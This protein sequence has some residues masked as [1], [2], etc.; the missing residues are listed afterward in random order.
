MVSQKQVLLHNSANAFAKHIH[1]RT[2]RRRDREREQRTGQKHWNE[3]Q[4]Q[5]KKNQKIYKALNDE[6]HKDMRIKNMLIYRGAN[7]AT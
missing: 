1:A 3:Q 4:K 6:F 5:M 7:A 2:P